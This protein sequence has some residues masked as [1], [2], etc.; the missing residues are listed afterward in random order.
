MTPNEIISKAKGECRHKWEEVKTLG[1]GERVKDNNPIDEAL[2]PCPYRL[3]CPICCKTKKVPFSEAHKLWE[4]KQSYHCDECNVQ[5]RI[6]S[7]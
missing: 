3:Q 4:K 5:L 1:K 6:I 7:G 2:A